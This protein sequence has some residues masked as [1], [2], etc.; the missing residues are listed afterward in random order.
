MTG[1]ALRGA[2]L[3]SQSCSR[4]HR[5]E[6]VGSEVGPDLRSIA[7]HPGEHLLKHVLQPDLFVSASYAAWKLVTNEKETFIGV[8]KRA[9]AESVVLLQSRGRE[10]VVRRSRIVSLEQTGHSFMP[11]DLLKD[12]TPAQVADLLAHIQ[13]VN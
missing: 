6:G 7:R 9:D 1:D 8:L 12:W 10:L 2:K 4:C 13:S 11:P 5:L 3:F